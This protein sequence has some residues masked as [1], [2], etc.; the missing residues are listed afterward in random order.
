MGSH[1]DRPRAMTAIAMTEREF[2][3]RVL[4]ALS[5]VNGSVRELEKSHIALREVVVRNDERLSRM[6]SDI[7]Q[8]RDADKDLRASDDTLKNI[9]ITDAQ[10]DA[11]AAQ[12]KLAAI[13]NRRRE[14]AKS[15]ALLVIGSLITLGLSLLK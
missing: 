8:L 2:Q 5:D 4:R 15:I 13:A 7:D 10:G 6:R 9:V 12:E 3:S 11:L 14:W 1:P